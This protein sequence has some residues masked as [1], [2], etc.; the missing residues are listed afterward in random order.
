MLVAPCLMRHFIAN[1]HSHGLVLFCIASIVSAAL[2]FT[3]LKHIP[4]TTRYLRHS[5]QQP[6]GG[7]GVIA[8]RTS[9][10]TA[11]IF[12]LTIEEMSR[13]KI[14]VC[15]YERHDSNSFINNFTFQFHTPAAPRAIPKPHS[16][17]I[18]NR[19]ATIPKAHGKGH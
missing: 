18:R 15:M 17:R 14:A 13:D 9:T 3:T 12:P 8:G 6:S 5:N 11:N 4:P 19:T 16:L 2:I 1:I 10:H 7:R